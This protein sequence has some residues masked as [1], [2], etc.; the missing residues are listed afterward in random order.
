MS[1]R[2]VYLSIIPDSTIRK[3]PDSFLESTASAALTCSVKSGCSGNFPHRSPFEELA[4][5]HAVHVAERKQAEQTARGGVSGR[6][7]HFRA[8]ERDRVTGLAE[9]GQ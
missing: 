6:G 2:C 8:G 9:A 4:I 7:T 3:N 5:E 1:R